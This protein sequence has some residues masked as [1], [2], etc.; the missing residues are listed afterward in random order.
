MLDNGKIAARIYLPDPEAGYYRGPRF[1]WSGMVHKVELNGHTFFGEWKAAPDP[2]A[3]DNVVGTAGEFG[4]N[5]PLGYDEAKP[6]GT[7]IKIGVGLLERINEDPYHFAKNY[8]VVTPLPWQ[9][10]KGDK[11]VEF[12]QALPPTNGWGYEYTKRIELSGDD[13]SMTIRYSLKNTGARPIV[14]DYYCH[15]FVVFDGRA[16]DPGIQVKLPF[17]SEKPRDIKGIASI[18]GDRVT[19]VKPLPPGQS[20]WHEFRA[21]PPGKESNAFTLTN[22]ETGQAVRIV[23]D[24]GPSKIVFYGIGKAVCVEPVIAIDLKP[25]EEKTWSD[26]YE[27]TKSH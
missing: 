19:L 17:Q 12:S 1:D 15:N 13:P 4:M 7:F 26:Q 14:T 8:R 27:F 18:D 25:G 24:T 6:G 21:F 20:L 11:W 5:S 3:T 23:G 2:K 16:L 9:V 22:P 10:N